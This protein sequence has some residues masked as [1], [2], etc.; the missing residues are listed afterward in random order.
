M[1]HFPEGL[2]FYLS[3]AFSG[4]FELPADFFEG[5]AVTIYEAKS[6]FEYLTF[7][8]GQSVQ[9]VTN[10]LAQ[11]DDSGHIA[12]I[13]SPFVFDEIAETRILTVTY[14]RLQRDWLLRHLQHGAHAF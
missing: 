3:D 11:Q 9:H 2:G 10:L 1:P 6:L 8:F 5:A 13:L 7:A 14:R 12:G 4:D